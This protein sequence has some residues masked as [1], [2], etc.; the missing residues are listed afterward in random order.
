MLYSNKIIED[1][2]KLN[3]LVSLESQ[4]KAVRLQDKHGKQ[5]LHEDMK[6]LLELITKSNEDI[7]EEVTKEK[8][9]TSN[10][11]KKALENLNNKPLEI[12]KDRCVI[13]SYLLSP[14]SKNT[15]HENTSHSKLVKDSNSNRVNDLLIHNTIPNTLL[16]NLLT[17]RD[18]GKVFELKGDLQ[19]M[20]TNKNYNV[21]LANLADKML[22]YD[23]P[24]QMNFDLKCLGGK[25][26]RDST[27]IN[28]L[29]SPGL[30]VCASGISNTTLVPSDP[31][32]LC[33]RLKLIMQ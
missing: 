28:L 6:K 22:M 4:I 3:E 1:S 15:N 10:N 23:F 27:F 21:D 16:Y 29:K 19:K 17:F 5:K 9:E 32:E 18:T 12:M 25:S 33:N 30:I 20:T 11:N 24:K 26:T 2:E 8:T 7:S 13:A 14:L 31:D